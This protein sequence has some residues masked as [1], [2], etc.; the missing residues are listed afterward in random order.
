[1]TSIRTVLELA[2]LLNPEVEQ[3]DVKSAFLHSDLE[4][5]VYMEQLEGFKQ[6]D[7]EDHVY[8]LKKN[9]YGLK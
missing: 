4:E 2:A 5:G 8:Q 6:K 7:K 3:M 1:M 9:L